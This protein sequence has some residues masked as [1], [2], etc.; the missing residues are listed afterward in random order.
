M[1]SV[2]NHEGVPATDT[3]SQITANS[4]TGSAMSAG[5]SIVQNASNSSNHTTLVAA[6]KAAG[7][8][9]TLS[10]AGPYTVF[11]P[12]NQAFSGLPAGAVDGLMNGGKKD[13][14]VSLLSYHVIAGA[15]KSADLKDG[16]MLKTIQG[17][18]LKV[19]V[20]DG[21]VSINNAR[22]TSPDL[23]SSNG[24]IHVIDGVLMPKK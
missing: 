5:S 20:K 13:E 10:G 3:S 8:I 19:S 11:A 12:T 21:T 4:Q 6:L 16:Q 17:A 15:I 14:L 2:T 22:V 23:I 9:E 24:V 18:S 1:P 7:L